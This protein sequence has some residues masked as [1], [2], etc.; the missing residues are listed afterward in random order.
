MTINTDVICTTICNNPRDCEY[1]CSQCTIKYDKIRM[2]HTFIVIV[3]V[4]VSQRNDYKFNNHVWSI[5]WSTTH[6]IVKF[7]VMFD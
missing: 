7:V 1:I 4:V 3:M 6:V 2:K 5:P